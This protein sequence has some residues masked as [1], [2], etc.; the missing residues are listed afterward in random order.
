MQDKVPTTVRKRKEAT[1]KG[2]RIFVFHDPSPIM[3]VWRAK[4]TM[5]K[6]HS[7]EF[8]KKKR[9]IPIAVKIYPALSKPA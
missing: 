4:L 2:S 6:I 7:L 3:Q 9:R 1:H 8:K 5:E